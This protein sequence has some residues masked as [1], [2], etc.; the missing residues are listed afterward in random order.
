M[1]WY[2]VRSLNAHG[3]RSDRALQ[4]MASFTRH[5]RRAH[6]HTWRTLESNESVPKWSRTRRACAGLVETSR[7]GK[8]MRS[9]PVPPFP[10][11]VDSFR[12]FIIV[13]ILALSTIFSSNTIQ[14]FDAGSLIRTLARNIASKLKIMSLKVDSCLLQMSEPCCRQTAGRQIV[15]LDVWVR[16]HRA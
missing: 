13:W 14:V 16:T 7:W 5:R 11:E 3:R 15:S 6:W 1:S 4:I 2:R 10:P 8:A 12:F 9:F